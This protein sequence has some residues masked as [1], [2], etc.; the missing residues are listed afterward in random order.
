M[1]NGKDGGKSSGKN[2][3]WKNSVDVKL[4]MA[5]PYFFFLTG[6][7]EI[8]DTL[9]EDLTITFPEL[10]DKSLGILDHSLH[11]NFMVELPWLMAQYAINDLFNPS[12]TIL[13]DVQDGDLANIP[14]HLNIKAI[15]IKSPYPFGHH[16]TKMSIFFYTDRSI[17]FA[18]YTANLIESDWEDRT[19]GVW[20]SP[21]CPYLGDDVPINY[22]ESDTL[23]K[24]EILQYL[25]S[26]KL[27]EIRNLLIKIQETDCSLIKVFFVSSVPGSVIDNFGYIKLGKIIK[28]HAVENSEDKERIVIQ[29]S[30]IG[31]LGPAPDSWLLNEF[32][33]STSSKLSSP[34]VSIV[35]PSVRNVASSIYGLSGGGCLPYSS[36]THIKQLWLNKYLM[37]WYCEHRKRSK[38]VPHIKTYARINEDKEEIS[39]F[40]LTSANLSK[41]AWGKKLKSGM[42]QIMSYEAG[43]L[44]LPKLLINKNVFKIKKFGYNSGNDD[45]FPIPYDIPLT[46][47]Q[48]TDRLFLFDKNFK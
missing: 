4:Q 26:Y 48:E 41:A 46:S 25:I 32:V 43:V 2:K 35:Y 7:N 11:I 38:A 39:W 33:K 42:L 15:K 30:S 34:Q 9:D 44:F 14:E 47:Y 24:F 17:R 16:H 12:M 31:S 19:Q 28:E 18:I 37:Q 21:K 45:E 36:G 20:I 3:K 13:Y 5:D 6:I 8:P 27:P 22:G 40:L 10:L 23:F 1:E 29:C